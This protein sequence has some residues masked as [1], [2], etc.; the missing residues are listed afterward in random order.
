MPRD[1]RPLTIEDCAKAG[2]TNG[3]AAQALG[4]SPSSFSRQKARRGLTFVDGRKTPKAV[5]RAR[6]RFERMRADPE[7]RDSINGGRQFPHIR[8]LAEAG[9]LA[10]YRRLIARRYVA[11]D[12]LRSVGRPDLIRLLPERGP[13]IPHIQILAEAGL[14]DDYRALTLAKI[15]AR[16]ALQSVGRPDLIRLLPKRGR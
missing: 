2:M 12:A 6:R 5:E 7:Q 16:E 14:L 9:L 3:E 13:Q 15:P 10:K 4:L 8:A 11:E 1:M